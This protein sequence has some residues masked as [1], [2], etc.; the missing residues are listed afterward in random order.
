M[1]HPGGVIFWNMKK[2]II[3]AATVSAL[4][5]FTG[6]AHA[7]PATA[8]VDLE[9]VSTTCDQPSEPPPLGDLV[10]NYSALNNDAPTIDE[11]PP[12]PTLPCAGGGEFGCSCAWAGVPFCYQ[13]CQPLGGC[14]TVCPHVL[15]CEWEDGTT[16]A[17]VLTIN[18]YT[19]AATM[20]RSIV[21]APAALTCIVEYDAAITFPP[22]GR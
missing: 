20:V 8:N 9:F 16:I 5:F 18:F 10:V 1:H 12:P 17:D 15:V 11:W 13:S 2:L 3:A 7:W 4:T 19:G 14:T 6:T 22:P 21:P